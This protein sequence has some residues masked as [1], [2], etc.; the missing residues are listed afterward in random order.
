MLP[1]TLREMK[2]AWRQNL[3]V[4]SVETRQNAHRLLLFYAVECGLKAVI[5]KREKVKRTDGC[6]ILSQL[7]HDINGLLNHC[8]AGSQLHLVSVKME[9]IKSPAT[10]RPVKPKEFNQMWR[11]GGKTEGTPADTDIETQLLGIVK[12]IEKEL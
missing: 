4:S 12:W 2:R 8:C 7:G 11:Y 6:T 5:M 10:S 9:D 1:F 3:E